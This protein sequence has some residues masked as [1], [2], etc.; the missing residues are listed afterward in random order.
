[1]L[2]LRCRDKDLDLRP[3]TS[4]LGLLVLLLDFKGKRLTGD[5]L[6]LRFLIGLRDRVRLRRLGVIDRFR[7]N[8][9]LINTCPT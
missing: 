4:R 9:D 5:K 3:D 7:S 2:Y 1:M 6:F 8:G